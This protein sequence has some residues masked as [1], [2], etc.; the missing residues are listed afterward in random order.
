MLANLDTA[1]LLSL[2]DVPNPVVETWLC[3]ELVEDD[4]DMQQCQEV[5]D[6]PDMMVVDIASTEGDSL[7]V[8][9]DCMEEH[10]EPVQVDD[11]EEVGIVVDMH[12]D[13]VVDGLEE[14]CTQMVVGKNVTEEL[15]EVVQV[16]AA[17]EED[18]G[19][20]YLLWV[21]DGVPVVVARVVNEKVEGMGMMEQKQEDQKGARED[22]DE[23]G[24]IGYVELMQRQFVKDAVYAECVETEYV[25]VECVEWAVVACFPADIRLTT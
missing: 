21:V 13:Y 4:G 25:V 2:R 11:L 19:S 16:V 7:R 6:T 18:N 1:D 5:V 17:M 12:S 22:A 3:Q 9:V 24:G 23:V 20:H 14:Q 8:E 10:D 15:L